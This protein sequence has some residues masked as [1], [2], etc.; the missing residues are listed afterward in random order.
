M[1]PTG[2]QDSFK[3]IPIRCYNEVWNIFNISWHYILFNEIFTL[4][5]ESIN[6]KG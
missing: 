4:E 6:P 3:H 5:F 2:D 1:E